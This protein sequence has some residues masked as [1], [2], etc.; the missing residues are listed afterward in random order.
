M[1]ISEEQPPRNQK[2]TNTACDRLYK[3]VHD[4]IARECMLQKQYNARHASV[5]NAYI[6]QTVSKDPCTWQKFSFL[7]PLP[8]LASES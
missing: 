8:S 4:G 2:Y 7:R 1:R 6:R 3:V 5:L